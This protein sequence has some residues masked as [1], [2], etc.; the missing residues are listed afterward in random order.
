MMIFPAGVIASEVET[1]TGRG[2]RTQLVLRPRNVETAA[3]EVY[4][5]PSGDM[6]IEVKPNEK[7]SRPEVLGMGL[8]F[9]G[10]EREDFF[11][12]IKE[13]APWKTWA[14]DMPRLS[15]IS[16]IVSPRR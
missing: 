1:G 2:N 11:A 15:A 9:L 10:D 12:M 3:S 6:S 5:Q 16:S 8:L 14:S 7:R 4:R 13:V